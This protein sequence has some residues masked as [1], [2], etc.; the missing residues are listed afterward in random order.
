M[1]TYIFA[2]FVQAVLCVL[3]AVTAYAEPSTGGPLFA[4]S[5]NRRA[6]VIDATYI[7]SASYSPQNARASVRKTVKRANAAG[8]KTRAGKF[9]RVNDPFQ[10]F[11][12]GRYEPERFPDAFSAEWFYWNSRLTRKPMPYHVH[13]VF[14]PPWRFGGVGAWKD[15]SRARLGGNSGSNVKQGCVAVGSAARYGNGGEP[16]LNLTDTIFLHEFFHCLGA[17]H[18]DAQPNIMSTDPLPLTD[19]TG[20][21]LPVLGETIDSLVGQI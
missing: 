15:G 10:T 20:P 21:L 1:L 4:G 14:S 19:K 2:S 17:Q 18:T 12:A 7:W 9:R 8:V 5:I 6:V 3:L 13:Y 16:W 11:S